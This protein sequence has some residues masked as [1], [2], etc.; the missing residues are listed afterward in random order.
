M[1]SVSGRDIVVVI[2]TL[3]EEHYIEDCLNSLMTGDKELESV[4]FIVADGGS[5]DDTRAI[6][7]RMMTSSPNLTLLDNPRRIQ[8]AAM[9]IAAQ[10]AP[11]DK[12]IMVRCDA[13]SIYPKNYVL[14]VAQTLREQ[15]VASVVVPMDAVCSKGCFQAANAWVVD[16]PLGNG[17]SAHRGGDY[18]G[19]V[20]HGHHAAFDRGVYLELGGYDEAFTHNEDAEYD[21]RVNAA[22]HTVYMD[23]AARIR[24]VPRDSFRG[25]WK[26][27]FNYGK[28]RAKN[29]KKHN[30]RPR[31]RQVIP[32]LNFLSLV[33]CAGSAA[34]WLQWGPQD[35]WMR[36]AGLGVLAFQPLLYLTALSLLSVTGAARLKSICGL[37]AGVVLACMHNSWALGFLMGALFTPTP[38]RT[39]SPLV[40][41]ETAS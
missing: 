8:S 16:S 38:D 19:P 20:D 29:L 31:L 36:W 27:Y 13:H 28:G 40:A 14:N 37:Y 11:R 17:G 32:L 39:Q 15:D 5:Q 18:S 26:Q 21:V 4:L 25:L 24:Y 34:A 10:W 7:R 3:N 12:N 2:P 9:N 35:G 33:A 30:G 6:V 23:A 22:G 1:P 41:R